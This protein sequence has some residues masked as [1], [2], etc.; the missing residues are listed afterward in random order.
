MRSICDHAGARLA[1]ASA[2]ENVGVWCDAC[3]GWVTQQLHGTPGPWLRRD[4]APLVGVSVEALPRVNAHLETCAIC[5]EE[6]ARYELHHWCPRRLYP[7]GS[8]PGEGPTA[9]LCVEC[10]AT[11]HR[12]V[13]P[14]LVGGVTPR[15]VLEMLR[16]F[17]RRMTAT[18]WRTFV[19]TVNDADAA[20]HRRRPPPPAQEAA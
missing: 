12:V 2:S 17:Q 4:A 7:A 11:W 10:H 20:R 13:T 16:G 3:D 15:R 6:T 9:I 18:E 14:L 8:I 19:T 1:R 5:R